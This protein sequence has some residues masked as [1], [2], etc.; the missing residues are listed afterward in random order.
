M[1]NFFLKNK[2]MNI[3]KFINYIK[4]IFYFVYSFLEIVLGGVVGSLGF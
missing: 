1:T 3:F 2:K 4:K